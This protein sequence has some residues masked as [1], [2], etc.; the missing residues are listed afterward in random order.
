MEVA[1]G[2]RALSEDGEVVAVATGST[3]EVTHAASADPVHR[4]TSRYTLRDVAA[5]SSGR[6][7]L[8]CVATSGGAKVLALRR[9]EGEDEA[10]ET[11]EAE[12][13]LH[14]TQP[15]ACAAFGATDEDRGTAE[16]ALG[17]YCGVITLW[18]VPFGLR[19]QPCE[20]TRTLRTGSSERITGLGFSRC[21]RYLSATDW[22]GNLFVFQR[23]VE[24]DGKGW[25]RL[26]RTHVPS[27]DE[28]IV[29]FVRWSSRGNL[30][31]VAPKEMDD[32]SR[33][34]FF[35]VEDK[36]AEEVARSPAPHHHDHRHRGRVAAIDVEETRVR[37]T[38]GEGREDDAAVVFLDW[39]CQMR[40]DPSSP[41]FADASWEIFCVQD[42]DYHARCRS[43]GDAQGSFDWEADNA[44]PSLRA[45]CCGRD[46]S[47]G[48]VEGVVPLDFLP[49]RWVTRLHSLGSQGGVISSKRD[50]H[51]GA[52]DR[53][54][55]VYANLAVYTLSADHL[56]DSRG[57]WEVRLLQ[58]PPQGSARLWLDQFTNA[59]EREAKGAR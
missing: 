10:W 36:W 37:L 1:T 29:S 48:R 28:K 46:V 30:F 40:E 11:R 22:L 31:L 27:C 23:V 59:E 54:I 8:V 9:G 49:P 15:V 5:C 34:H 45:V 17:W 58:H 35:R 20:Q 53:T 50:A 26:A 18:V 6:D 44:P 32:R 55:V 43:A 19:R 14:Y 13:M 51:V 4:E 42:Q 7:Y 12:D 16:L 2:S 24:N 56:G 39:P 3:I 38:L 41:I 33:V 47:G 21:G 57:K 52:K 25:L